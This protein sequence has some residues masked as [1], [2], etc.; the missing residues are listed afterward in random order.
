MAPRRIHTALQ[1]LPAQEP[2]DPAA[3]RR[4]RHH[5]ALELSAAAHARARD[6]R[7]RRRQPRDDQAGRAD[8]AFLRAA[9]GSDRAKIRCHRAAR[10]RHRG[11][12]RESV[13][14]TAV[15]SSDLHR[16]DAGRAHRRRGR[17]AQ[18]HAGDARARRQVARDR[19]PHRRSQRG[20]RA[21]RLRQTAQCRA[22]LHRAG[23]CAGAGRIRAG[24]CREG[25]HAYAPDVRHR[26]EQQGLHLDHLRPALCAAGER[27]SRMPR[28][29]AQR[30]CNRR[31]PDDPNWK[32]QAQ[33][34]ADAGGRRD[35]R[36]GPDAGG[37]FWTGAAR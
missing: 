13:P 34:P 27:W 10:H 5:R 4:G 32:A 23:L 16:L 36:D 24:L 20:R 31:R 21:H 37:D 14:D 30:S 18:S 17:G 33:I 26:A 29:R 25:A 2:A 12:G 1:F 11:R 9:E 3:A 7:D 8:A 28:P 6:R 19:R 22:D 35:G 15:R